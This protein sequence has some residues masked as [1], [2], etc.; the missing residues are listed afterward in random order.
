VISY[1]AQREAIE[2]GARNVKRGQS[3]R[4]AVEVADSGDSHTARA[5][6]ARLEGGS[7]E[8]NGLTYLGYAS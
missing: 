1:L 2:D 8:A 5:G 7:I 3:G 4:P 6:G